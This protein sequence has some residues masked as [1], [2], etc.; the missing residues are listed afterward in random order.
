VIP[1][2]KAAAGVAVLKDRK[3]KV[4]VA[5][6]RAGVVGAYQRI[7]VDSIEAN[8]WNP[9]ILPAESMTKLRVG[10]AEMLRKHGSIP[11]II[12]RPHPDDRNNRFQIIDG[13]HRWR[14]VRGEK[15]NDR[16]A[17]EID[18]F[19]IDVDDALAK[20]LTLNLNYLRGEPNEAKEADILSDLVKAG[21]KPEELSESLYMDTQTILD[22]LLAYDKNDAMMEVLRQESTDSAAKGKEEDSEI[23]DDDVFLE[24]TFKVS[25]AQA[26]VIE[27]EIER[28]A[29]KLKGRN[30]RGRSMEFMAVQSSQT[31]LPDDLV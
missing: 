14:I 3:T 13:E 17:E 21:W 23:L 30:T 15:G 16:L 28:I 22:T 1:V 5:V 12:A 8:P 2:K 24:L 9:N 27:K 11:P 4:Q 7:P 6:Q 26:K 19:I 18:A 25:G 10:V 31:R 29:S 20:R